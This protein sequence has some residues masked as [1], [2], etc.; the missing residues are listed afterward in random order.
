MDQQVF[1][2]WFHLS[3]RR[4]HKRLMAYTATFDPCELIHSHAIDGLE[5]RE[6]RL[7]N[8]LGTVVDPVYLGD[9][10]RGRSG[11]VEGEPIPGNWHACVAEWGACLRAL[12][13]ARKTFT[14]IELGCGW[15]C[16]LN[17]MAVAARNV[18]MQYE[19]VGV[20]GDT[21]HLAFARKTFQENGMPLEKVA[22]HTG[23]A[24]AEDGF[25]LFPRQQHKGVSWGL[26]PVFGATESQRLAAVQSATHD[27]LP[28]LSLDR[29]IGS[30]PRVDLLHIDIQGGEL[31]LLAGSLPILAEKVA[32]IFVA[33]HSRS[34]EKSI[35]RV[36]S[37]DQWILEIERPAI[38]TM[39]MTGPR[40]KIDGV[41]G[42]RNTR[43]LP[44]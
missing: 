23:I 32:Y 30:R 18:G 22:L 2:E 17:N 19:L 21:D 41:M 12:H 28:M 15:G 39:R 14:V 33:T 26:Q 24:A 7:T 4:I 42:W 34:I 35:H 44:A 29:V 11:L 38:C 5:P 16:W 36:M 43:L 37:G 1:K 27:E 9:T 13:L 8:F 10:L 6:G 40:L 20:E 31:A 25:A 3:P